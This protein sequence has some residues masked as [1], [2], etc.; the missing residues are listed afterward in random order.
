M[1]EI[2]V[3]VAIIGSGIIGTACADELTGLGFTV[4][5]IDRAEPCAGAT[6]AC[7]GFVCMSTKVPGITLDL[8]AESQRLWQNLADTIGRDIGYSRPGALVVAETEIEPQALERHAEKLWA[9]GVVA[10]LHD[11]NGLLAIEPN[12]GPRVH[13]AL[14]C[15]GDAHVVGFLAAQAL[16][17]RAIE[18]GA[19]PLW[20]CD[21]APFEL[22]SSEIRRVVLK[23]G[24][25][26]VCVA[27]EQWLLAAG[28]GSRAIG[29]QLGLPL[30]IEPRRGD[31]VVTDR[32]ARP[33][34]RHLCSSAHYLVAK[35]NPALAET[36]DDP[37]IRLGYGFIAEPTGEG[38][39]ILGS[40]RIFRGED[41]RSDI[42]V[43]RMILDEAVA[44]LPDL[45]GAP[46][47]RS[48]AGLRP[49]VPD[50]KPIIGRS[51]RWTNLLVATGHEGDGIALAPI[52]GR[53]VGELARGRAPSFPLD[54][55]SPDRFSPSVP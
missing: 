35:G 14:H 41:R 34:I 55:L 27:A 44:R 1:R 45:A 29:E 40:S 47:L 4:A 31:L 12:F 30:P 49:F 9:A 32:L 48:F 33:L 53:L 20:R 15:P 42:D 24:G 25:N 28:L 16:A 22:G 39:M 8:A 37:R 26:S 5:L 51:R 50:G 13:A 21:L 43:V 17:A 46:I 18:R 38:Q 52:T 11:R 54:V 19:I 3:D 2:R 23:T 36:S 10:E 7:D 6:G